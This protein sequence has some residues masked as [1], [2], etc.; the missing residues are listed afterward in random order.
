MLLNALEHVNQFLETVNIISNM[1]VDKLPLSIANPDVPPL[2][3]LDKE[4]EHIEKM[5]KIFL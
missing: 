1:P 2:R 4:Q 3:V 5:K